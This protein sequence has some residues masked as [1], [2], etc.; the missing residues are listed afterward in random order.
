[1]SDK[2]LNLLGFDYYQ[3]F[4]GTPERRMNYTTQLLQEVSDAFDL[5]STSNEWIGVVLSG[6][7]GNK[8]ETFLDSVHANDF[9]LVD[10]GDGI[11]RTSMRIRVFD[12]ETYGLDKFNPCTLLPDPFEKGITMVEKQWRISLHPTAYTLYNSGEQTSYNFGQLVSLREEDGTFFVTKNMANPWGAAGTNTEEEPDY[13]WSLTV[14]DR[15]SNGK[16]KRGA[17]NYTWEEYKELARTGVFDE[18]L[19]Y[20]GDHECGRGP[21][22]CASSFGDDQYRAWN[23]DRK[24]DAVKPTGNDKYIDTTKTGGKTN[25]TQFTIEQMQWSMRPPR[26][27]GHR[28]KWIAKG[29]KQP[30]LINKS[31]AAGSWFATG[32]YQITPGFLFPAVDRI[33]GLNTGELYDKETQD[34]LAIYGL[35]WKRSSTIGEY[36]M[37]GKATVT[38]AGDAMAQE[39]ASIRLQSDQPNGAKRGQRYF[40]D[41][42]NTR[43]KVT[44][45]SLRD[46]EKAAK[47]LAETRKKIDGTEGVEVRR[48]RDE[49]QERDAKEAKEKAEKKKAEREAKEAEREAKR[50]AIKAK[51]KAK[52]EARKKAREEAKKAREEA[53]KKKRNR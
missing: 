23:Y 16:K 49:A 38:Q 28:K 53:R 47:L 12:S 14:D 35:L 37:G 15:V 51:H 11:P 39:W 17:I 8:S 29:W 40:S 19:Q 20:I 22:R 9:E 45:S 52:R 43:G 27:T 33:K 24:R 21:K 3:F 4:S 48:I 34:A 2:W 25:M 18:L 7:K 44:A 13:D 41:A 1:M 5:S 26:K 50:E 10:I 31:D 42:T 6:E 36:L 46:A 30:L 32:K